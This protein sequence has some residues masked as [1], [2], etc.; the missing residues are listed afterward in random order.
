MPGLRAILDRERLA[1]GGRRAV[2]LL[3]AFLASLPLCAF[4][5]VQPQLVVALPV[6]GLLVLTVGRPRLG[7]LVL[8][9]LSPFGHLVGGL[10]GFHL[11]L[12][13]PL[14][15]AFL[16]GWLVREAIGKEDTAS[17]AAHPSRLPLVLAGL[18]AL[19]VTASLAVH[20][21]VVQISTA[22]PG[23]FARVLWRFLWHDYYLPSG[24]RLPAV[25]GSALMLAQTGLFGAT[26]LLSRRC[27]GL[28]RRGAAVVVG[29]AAFAASLNIAELVQQGEASSL[30]EAFSLRISHAFPDVN[31]AGSYFAM[32]LVLAVGLLVSARRW[33]WLWAAA[34]VLL[35]AGLWLSGS[36]TAWAALPVVGLCLGALI[37]VRS[38]ASM[39]RRFLAGAI[40]G[41]VLTGLFL[42]TSNRSTALSARIA[43]GWRVEMAK[44]AVGMFRDY[45]VFGIG[46][47]RFWRLSS[48]YV[49]SSNPLPV[50]R[51]NAHNNFLQ[52]LAELGL[53]GFGYLTGLL[54]VV[55]A[56]PLRQWRAPV[57]DPLRASMV[58]ACLVFVATWFSGHPLLTREV[59]LAFWLVLGLLAA[60]D[61]GIA[62]ELQPAADEHPRRRIALPAT[63]VLLTVAL[64]P[65]VADQR[66]AR[67]DLS[68]GG[69]GFSAWHRT[70]DGTRYRW[71]NRRAVL[72]IPATARRV[73][74]PLRAPGG[75]ATIRLQAGHAQ[76]AVQI[77]AGPQW[78]EARLDVPEGS[79][80]ASV[81]V[82]LEVRTF[83]PSTCANPGESR[84]QVGL[85]FDSGP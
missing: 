79:R 72:Y 44:R 69:R 47:G 55:F 4:V 36:R 14:L 61:R 48:A 28:A 52:V 18:L 54:M 73:S 19:A 51:E 12:A 78:E 80:W 43:M 41:C 20:L 31:A 25:S 64:V 32:C 7:L 22:Y 49:S 77:L 46:V 53:V 3:L 10:A 76:P 8:A 27:D 29:A 37:A 59:A 16:A 35:L 68:R 82:E 39:A 13:E 33:R 30:R 70:A 42:T 9:A 66:L 57:G 50:T 60:T 75:V 84:V 85:P 38:G 2:C 24:E 81:P 58:A 6:A 40:A 34:G 1:R 11:K 15:F 71:M 26:V 83:L 5:V 63:A 23:D 62:Q 45:P 56:R 65:L 21:I 17:Q 67:A 74:I